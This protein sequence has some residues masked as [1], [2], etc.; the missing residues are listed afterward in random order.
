VIAAAA[1]DM[2]VLDPFQPEMRSLRAHRQNVLMQGPVAST[3]AVLR[4]LRPHIREPILWNRPE[5]PLRLQT[6]GTGALV[7]REV[8]ALSTGDQTRLLE[9]LAGPGSHTQVVSTTAHSLFTL[10]SRGVFDSALY[11]R[12]NAVLL[13]V[14]PTNPP[15][16]DRQF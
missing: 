11:Y 8:A 5:R 10:V 9:W 4:L 1:T 14:R 2:S 13:H 16:A 15:V 12:L 6:E 3:D 7:L